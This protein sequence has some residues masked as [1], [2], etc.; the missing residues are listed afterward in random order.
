MLTCFRSY[1]QGRK[2]VIRMLGG[3]YSQAEVTFIFKH[4]YIFKLLYFSCCGDGV[5]C[6][7]D[8]IS[9]VKVARVYKQPVSD[10]LS[11]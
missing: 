8:S 4:K 6:L 3:A 9:Q 11:Y 10:V 1:S 2:T 7:L 5:F